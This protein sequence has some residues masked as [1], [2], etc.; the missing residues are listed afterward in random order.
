VP[1]GGLLSILIGHANVGGLGYVTVGATVLLELWRSKH[2]KDH[3]FVKVFSILFKKNKLNTSKNIDRI[4][5]II[6]A[7]GW[8]FSITSL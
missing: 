7:Y 2:N 3:F 6:S 4:F 5:P 8:I 1:I